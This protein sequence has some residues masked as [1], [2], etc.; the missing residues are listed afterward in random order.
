MKLSGKVASYASLALLVGSTFFS[1]CVS[2]NY[3]K[4]DV[5]V[6]PSTTV[7]L[8]PLDYNPSFLQKKA[9]YEF[10]HPVSKDL[11][12]VIET[13]H[14]F[15][16]EEDATLLLTGD[17]WC[18]YC[19]QL[20]EYEDRIGL[21]SDLKIDY[22]ESNILHWHA[23]NTELKKEGLPA[24]INL[25]TMLKKQG[26]DI[27]MFYGFDNVRGTM[28]SEDKKSVSLEKILR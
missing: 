19:K 4:S 14:R 9:L 8:T 23:I 1:R 2:P 27:R 20:S 28:K 11:K 24:G 26:E 5:L 3:E 16:Q 17:D 21:H 15:K 13:I 12:S 6:P 22:K 18:L 25:P 10:D 7:V